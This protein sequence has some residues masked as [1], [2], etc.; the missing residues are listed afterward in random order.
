MTMQFRVPLIVR[1][2]ALITASLFA[3]NCECQAQVSGATV[4]VK[5]PPHKAVGRI[6]DMGVIKRQF[7]TDLNKF[8]AKLAQGEQVYPADHSL[9]LELNFY[10]ASDLS[11][12]DKLDKDALA[13]IDF[14]QLVVKSHNYKYLSRLDGLGRIIMSNTEVDD[15]DL[16]QIGKVK[17]LKDL[18][19][20]KTN[21][22]GAGLKYLTQAKSLKRLDLSFDPINQ[23][24]LKSICDLP[25]L[26]TL[27]MANCHLTNDSLFYIAKA[28][29]LRR[30]SLGFNSHI[31]D[32]AVE[33]LAACPRLAK[34]E[35]NGTAITYNGLAKLAKRRKLAN[36]KISA[37]KFDEEKVRQ[38]KIL[39]PGCDIK[40]VK[41]EGKMEPDLFAPLH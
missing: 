27:F 29:K 26:E 33:F 24:Q 15:K 35:I 3:A 6:I 25:S 37:E 22:T 40:A 21:V 7:P 16:E 38:L 4:T 30:L 39:M 12:L 9:H 8:P 5:F 20:N 10:G 13:S 2:M 31:N 34:L 14:N 41:S 32:N 1:L 36:L 19:I 18:V 23:A 11:W 17:N 28:P